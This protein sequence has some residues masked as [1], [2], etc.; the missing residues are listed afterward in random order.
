MPKREK[1]PRR[2]HKIMKINGLIGIWRWV[3][4]EE[5]DLFYNLIHR[6]YDIFCHPFIIYESV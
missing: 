5:S 3:I 4:R 6:V 2:F 1:N